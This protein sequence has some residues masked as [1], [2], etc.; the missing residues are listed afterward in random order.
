MEERDCDAASGLVNE[1]DGRA[2]HDVKTYVAHHF[3]IVRGS[4][5]TTNS[6]VPSHVELMAPT[7]HA[8]RELGGS[9]SIDEILQQVIANLRLPVEITGVLHLDGPRTELAYRLGWSRTY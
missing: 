8:I 9:A 6:D 1:K 7:L 3:E 4:I 5:V 2:R